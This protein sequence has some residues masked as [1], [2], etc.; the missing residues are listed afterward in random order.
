MDHRRNET[1]CITSQLRLSGTIAAMKLDDCGHIESE[2]AEK[3]PIGQVQS[4]YSRLARSST[5]SI[6]SIAV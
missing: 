5:A 2:E 1:A 4:A 3:G 6:R